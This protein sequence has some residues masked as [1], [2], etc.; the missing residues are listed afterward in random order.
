MAP[1]VIRR[2]DIANVRVGDDVSQL[3][4]SFTGRDRLGV[5]LRALTSDDFNRW[6]AAL[7]TPA[8]QLPAAMALMAAQTCAHS[9]TVAAAHDWLRREVERDEGAGMISTAAE[10]AARE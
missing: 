4:F 10:A 1:T 8:D 3:A 7:Q 9:V 5:R 2:A 6:V